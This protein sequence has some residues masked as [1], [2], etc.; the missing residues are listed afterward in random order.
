MITLTD[1]L[2]D[3]IADNPFLQFGIQKRIFNLSSLSRELQPQVEIRAK[4]DVRSSAILM[5]L[6]RL[7]RAEQKKVP[8][9]EQIHAKS[10]TIQTGLSIYTFTKT[11]DVHKGMNMLFIELQ[12]NNGYITIC[13]GTQEIT[14][15][16]D[17]A[18][19]H[20][21]KH[22][23]P[24]QPKYHQDRL[25]AL[26]L[27]FD[28][29]LYLPTPGMIYLVLQQLMLQSINLIEVSSTYTELTLYVAEQDAKL[30]FETLYRLINAGK[31]F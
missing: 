7:Q 25:A 30:A 2:R 24:Q 17:S 13:E 12:K 27:S 15:L 28:E 9:R 16:L 21:V 8:Q 11:K 19:A 4:K 18:H 10:V 5:A 20:R 31:D 29:K 22:F 6:S 14:I 26:G 3:I 23:M 1:V